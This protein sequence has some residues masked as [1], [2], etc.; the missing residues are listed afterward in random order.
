LLNGSSYNF[1]FV[2]GEQGRG[3]EKVILSRKEPSF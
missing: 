2:D 3:L 1:I